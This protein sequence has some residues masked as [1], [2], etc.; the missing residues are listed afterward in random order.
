MK[1][2]MITKDY[3]GR[4]TFA[5]MTHKDSMILA[6][7]MNPKPR[8]YADRFETVK[9]YIERTGC[10]TDLRMSKK[11]VELIK[12][13]YHTGDVKEYPLDQIGRTCT[14]IPKD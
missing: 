13:Y 5:G 11:G 9:E 6:R 4:L 3:K 7:M 14:Y 1:D 8:E 12:V 10:K 2:M